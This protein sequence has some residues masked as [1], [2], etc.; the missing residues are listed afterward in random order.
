MR[1]KVT[2]DSYLRAYRDTEEN[3]KRNDLKRIAV[4]RLNARCWR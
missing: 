2:T 4:Y 1:A 3:E